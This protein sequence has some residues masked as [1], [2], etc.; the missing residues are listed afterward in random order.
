MIKDS[1]DQLP[2]QNNEKFHDCS[3]SEIL[4]TIFKNIE[5]LYEPQRMVTGIST[6]FSELDILTTGL[7][8]GDLI[9]VAGRPGMGKTAFAQGIVQ[10]ATMHAEDSV[11]AVIF[12]QEM[13]KEQM[14]LR[15]LSSES[16][17][18]FSRLGT[19]CLDE[20]DWPKL[21]MAAAS[22][23]NEKLF[24]DDTPG[25]SVSELCARA[26]H[27]KSRDDLG[28]IVID[29]LQLLNGDHAENR[30]EEIFEIVRS[31]KSLAKELD[32]PV[33][34]LSQLN[35]SL[36]SR[37]DRRPIMADLREYENVEQY[38]DTILFLYRE[39][40]YCQACKNVD[41]I[42]DKE[43]R[44]DDEIIVGKQRNG[45]IGTISATFITE[46]LR[47]EDKLTISERS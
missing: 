26:R 6:G 1:P 11:S 40:V 37:R 17:V 12:T 44:T 21:T 18:E 32:I 15:I 29:Y 14:M 33:I 25:I 9:I 36:E 19:V 47:F 4:R 8:G 43:H 27:L 24:I 5:K 45:S 2:P 41:E 35:R 23:S 10:H 7:Q 20:S 28:L 30:R 39:S 46:F 16:R 42:C 38:V 3:S 22:L 31:L 13:T 34:V